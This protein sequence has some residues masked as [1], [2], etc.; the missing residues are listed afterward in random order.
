MDHLTVVI[1]G[2]KNDQLLGLL[3]DLHIAQ[4][5]FEFDGLDAIGT[6]TEANAKVLYAA[7][8]EAART[9]WE[10][11]SA[12]VFEFDSAFFPAGPTAIHPVRQLRGKVA[13]RL[14]RRRENLAPACA[15]PG[16][17]F[18]TAKA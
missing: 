3:N 5:S 16:L 18:G 12:D 17:I 2:C 15:S 13:A 6:L 7:L 8:D 9:A 10:D 4:T 11:E 1:T 14:S